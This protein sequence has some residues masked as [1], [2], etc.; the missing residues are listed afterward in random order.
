MRSERPSLVTVTD[1]AR[2]FADYINRVAFEGERFVLTRGNKPV[3]E[4]G[5]VARGRTLGELAS[6]L[7]TLPRLT[8]EEAK[9]F[10]EDLEQARAELS[11]EELDERWGS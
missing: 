9:S 2:R 8:D 1:V 4:L 5:P 10:R 11:G 3:A 7:E 6:L